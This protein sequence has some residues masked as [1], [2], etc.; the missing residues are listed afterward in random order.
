[1]RLL[2]I[3]LHIRL[4]LPINFVRVSVPDWCEAL[5]SSASDDA[6][7]VDAPLNLEREGLAE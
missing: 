4:A 3:R 1:L 6:A 2:A 7:V 5:V